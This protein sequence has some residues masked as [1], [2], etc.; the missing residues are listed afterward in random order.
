MPHY[1][2]SSTVADK[3]ARYRVPLGENPDTA[4]EAAAY[5]LL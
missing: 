5:S 3:L 2:V 1:V 4:S